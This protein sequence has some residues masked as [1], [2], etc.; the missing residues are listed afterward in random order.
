MSGLSRKRERLLFASVVTLLSSVSAGFAV[1]FYQLTKRHGQLLLELEA[2]GRSPDQ[3]QGNGQEQDPRAH[4]FGQGPP[5]GSVSMNFELKGVDGIFYTLTRLKRQRTVLVFIAPDCAESISLLQSLSRLPVDLD[6]PHCRVAFISS[7]TLDENA[8]L[9]KRFGLQAPLLV[10]ERDEVY[11]LYYVPGTPMAYVIGADSVTETARL[12]GE[13][14][15]LGAVTACLLD[16]GAV[17]GY[18]VRPLPKFSSTVPAPLNAGDRFPPVSLPLLNGGEL[19]KSDFLGQR[20]LLFMFDPHCEPCVDLLS[21]IQKAHLDSDLP[22]VVMIARRDP[23]LTRQIADEKRLSFPIGIQD[24][25]E[26][27]RAIG[28]LATPAACVVDRDGYLETGIARGGRAVATLIRRS[29]QEPPTRRLTS[30]TSLLHRT[31]VG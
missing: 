11:D 22:N 26:A 1:L 20:T 3:T 25:W 29:G 23:A 13:Q 24:N 12:E 10:Q 28:M 7:G 16:A 17:P 8:E 15:I 31:W 27:S 2:G 6:P 9:A 21:D 18:Q 4:L 30:L 19:S 14:T 5:A